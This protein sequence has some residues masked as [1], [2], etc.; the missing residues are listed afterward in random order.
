MHLFEFMDQSWVP[1]SLH[2]TMREILECGNSWPFRRYNDWVV[3]ELLRVAK[4]AGAT[5]VIELGAGTAPLTRH[6]LRCPAADSLDLVVC[7]S[8]PDAECYRE[9]AESSQGRV[10]PIYEPVDFSQ[11]REWPPGALLVLS[12]TLHHVP[13]EHRMQVLNAL[14]SN[15]A[16]VLVF[17]PLRQ[18]LWSML[19]VPLSIVPALLTPLR[20]IGRAGRLRRFVW[21]WFL[22]IAPFM[23]WWDGLVSC[24][25]Q[26]TVAD[27]NRRLEGGAVHKREWEI[28]SRFF[29]QLVEISAAA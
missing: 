1:G 23:F 11:P 20:F 14:Q 12:A 6:L 8:T 15:G 7:D 24:L 4:E 5:S 29:S 26:W 17:E 27:C 18:N 10:K 16:K 19:F 21:C 25:R 2:A 9:L 22:P 28:Q 3:Q 13:A